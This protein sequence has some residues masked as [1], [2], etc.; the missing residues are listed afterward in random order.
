MN[1]VTPV[2]KSVPRA[3]AT[4][5]LRPSFVITVQRGA[6]GSHLAVNVSVTA[7]PVKS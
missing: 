6:Q 4:L 7:R 2:L 5:F 3:Q 1:T